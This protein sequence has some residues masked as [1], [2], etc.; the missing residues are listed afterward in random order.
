MTAPHLTFR[1]F[2]L[3]PVVVPVPR[4]LVTKVVTVGR[5]PLLLIDLETEE[6][7]TGRAYLFGYLP[8]GPSFILPVLRAIEA[9][10][11]G[12]PLAPARQFDSLTRALGLLGPEGIAAVASAGSGGIP[13]RP[14]YLAAR[15]TVRKR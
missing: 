9:R 2:T 5:A 12:Q 15:W 13:G 11:K 1:S 7:V 14:W 10:V 8:E 3:T 4:P 6:G